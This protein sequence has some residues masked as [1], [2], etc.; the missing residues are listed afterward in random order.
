MTLDLKATK[1]GPMVNRAVVVG[2]GGLSVKAEAAIEVSGSKIVLSRSGPPRR[3]L[4]RP[5]VYSNTLMNESKYDVDGVVAVESVPAGMEFAGASHGGQFNEGTRTIAWRIERMAPGETCVVK[6]KLDSQGD[7]H[8]DQH[9]ARLGPQ[10]RTGGGDV[11]NDRR[12]LRR[13]GR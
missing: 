1:I 9:G 7:R 8:T 5:A 13:S 6:S 3:Y 12:G 11:R 4:G 10:R 2:E